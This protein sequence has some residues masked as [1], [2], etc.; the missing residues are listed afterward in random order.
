M[1]R[2]TTIEELLS[3]Q[4]VEI[5]T[6]SQSDSEQ[7]ERMSVLEDDVDTWDD[8]VIALEAADRDIQTRLATLEETILSI[9]CFCK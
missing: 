2:L 5:A 1:V 3:A 8:R 4:T 7:N 6:I 9:F